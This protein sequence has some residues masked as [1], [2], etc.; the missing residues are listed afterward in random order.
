MNSLHEILQSVARELD[1]LA[2]SWALVGGL[3]A[4][5]E[6]RFTRDVDIAVRVADD[7]A[8]EAVV[9]GLMGRGYGIGAVLM[10]L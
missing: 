8:A 3:G 6:P 4:R 9:R 10:R 1:G 2:V 7:V 5:T